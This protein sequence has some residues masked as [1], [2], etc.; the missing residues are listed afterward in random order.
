M[1]YT[2][3][4]SQSSR[5]WEVQDQDAGRS[6]VWWGNLLPGLQIAV[7]LLY[8]YV[9]ENRNSFLASSCKDANPIHEGF[10]LMTLLPSKSLTS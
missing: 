6:G 1:A 8:P 10:T 5:G 2:T 7:F 9:A 4:I 3:E